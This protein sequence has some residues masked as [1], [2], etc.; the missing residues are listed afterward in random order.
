MEYKSSHIS[1]KFPLRSLGLIG[2]MG[3]SCK[4]VSNDMAV[5]FD[6]AD[7]F[8]LDHFD[9]Y[10]HLIFW[11]KVNKDTVFEASVLE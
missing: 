3:L 11:M 7:S 1:I 5:D 10:I 6:Y 9:Q 4:M 2:H 8:E